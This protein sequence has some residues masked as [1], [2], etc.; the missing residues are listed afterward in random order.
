MITEKEGEK[1]TR[2]MKRKRIVR[3][4]SSLGTGFI[5][6][7]ARGYNTGY[8]EGYRQ[9][10]NAGKAGFHLRFKG[11]SIIIPT[12]N[13]IH[14][15]RQCIE[16]I[17][18]YTCEPYEIIVI[19]NGSKDGTVEYLRK[20]QGNIR[21]RIPSTN[22]GFAGAVNQGLMMAKGDMI[23]ILNDDTVVTTNWL[24]NL[25]H[26]LN[27]DHAVGIVGPV[28][29]YI[30]GEQQ[31]DTR[32]DSI[33]AMQEFACSYNHSD[34][35]RWVPT[36]R[37]T[38]FCMLMRRETFHRLGYFDEGYEMGNCEDD[39]YN[40]RARLLGLNLVIAK[41]T[42]IYH[43]GSVSMKSLGPDFETVYGKNLAFYSK[44]WG[45]QARVLVAAHQAIHSGN[46]KSNDF[47]P[48]SVAVQG[49]GSTVYWIENG[50]RY[51]IDIPPEMPVTRIS[52][53]DLWN[54][55][56]GPTLSS[57]Q[58][59]QHFSHFSNILSRESS[60]PDGILLQTPDS[61]IFQYDQGRLR[62]VINEWALTIWQLHQRRVFPITFEEK[63]RIPEGN[64]IIAP[65]V[66]KAEN[67]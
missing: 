64:P 11:T 29:N 23:M 52:Q 38:G 63:K 15:L 57:K 65:P 31:I 4:G 44:K 36:G 25:I 14:Y 1:A 45:D 12:C 13:N 35:G 56:I 58:L 46:P 37:L 33:N 53:I 34:P 60:Y 40:L 28:T 62:W 41:D 26:C 7:Y 20:V 32:F 47:Y 55:P 59:L 66:L 16:S 21:M 3:K 22:L 10:C 39:D 9:G 54:W 30:S 19:V 49:T 48:T 67:I 61:K 17:Q 5:A 6:G 43:Y 18:T 24:T 8:D 42:F 27:S 50:I 2:R 51:P